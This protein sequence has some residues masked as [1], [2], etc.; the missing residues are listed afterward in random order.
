MEYKKIDSGA[1][2][3]RLDSGEE[4]VSS[5]VTTCKKNKIQCALVS[6]LGACRK[7]EIAH[8]DPGAKKYHNKKFEGKMEI[9][10]LLGNIT[11]SEGGKEPIAHLHI[12]LGLED[13]SVV[14]GHLVSAEINP[15]CEITITPLNAKI[16]RKFDER[17][18]L[19]LQRFLQ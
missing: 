19:K 8:Y 16:E 6:G 11:M 17:S 3:L 14:G 4:I 2:L 5:L 1:V 13:F 15:T 18:G 12:A 7:A 9:V 10:S